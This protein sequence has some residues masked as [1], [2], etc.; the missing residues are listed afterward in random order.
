MKRLKICFAL[1]F[2]GLFFISMATILEIRASVDPQMSLSQ[3]H[4]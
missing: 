1:W 2:V 3:R 4:K